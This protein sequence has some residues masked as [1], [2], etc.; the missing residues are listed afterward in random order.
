MCDACQWCKD[1][2]AHIAECLGV[3]WFEAHLAVVFL[4][5]TVCGQLWFL[6]STVRLIAHMPLPQAGAS[7]R[8]LQAGCL[9]MHELAVYCH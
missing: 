2:D 7:H 1:G 6:W 8:F 3:A 9:R 5:P 4:T